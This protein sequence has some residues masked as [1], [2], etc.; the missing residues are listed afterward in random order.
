MSGKTPSI[1]LSEALTY[2]TDRAAAIR[3]L[4]LPTKVFTLH[5]SGTIRGFEESMG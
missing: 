2:L 3:D 1:T 5:I 4:K